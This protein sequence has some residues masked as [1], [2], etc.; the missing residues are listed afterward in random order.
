[1]SS[2]GLRGGNEYLDFRKNVCTVQ[3]T[4]L[5]ICKSDG[6]INDVQYLCLIIR[7]SKVVVI[8]AR[9]GGENGT[10]IRGDGGSYQQRRRE[11]SIL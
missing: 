11:S 5:N 4:L 7:K 6:A 1:M 10:A 9:S 2:A 8:L 3:L